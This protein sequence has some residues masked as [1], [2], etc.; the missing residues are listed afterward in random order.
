MEQSV[1]I[2]PDAPDVHFYL[3]EIYFELDDF[4]AAL[5][6]Y[7]QAI[8]LDS[9]F[10]PAYVGRAKARLALDPEVDVSRDFQ[11]AINSDPEYPFV[12]IQRAAFFIFQEDYEAALEDLKAAESLVPESSLIRL[13]RAQIAFSQGDLDSALVFAQDAL[14]REPTSLPSYRILAFV[15][16]ALGN[17][18]A[19]LEPLET[20]TRYIRSDQ[21]AIILLGDTYARLDR[22]QDA[23]WLYERIL[24]EDDTQADV[25]YHRGLA[26]LWSGEAEKALSDFN[27][28][29]RLRRSVF[30]YNIG[31]GR[32]LTALDSP[33]SAY[34]YYNEIAFMAKTNAQLAELYYYRGLSLEALDEVNLELNQWRQLLTLPEDDIP[35]EYWDHA[36][37]R[38]LILDPP[39]PTA[40]RTTTPSATAAPSLTASVEP[41][42]TVTPPATETATVTATPFPSE[43]SSPSPTT[44]P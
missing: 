43:T 6:A 25:F 41:S 36:P 27:A 18:E 37:A 33:G 21:D 39:T 13:Y 38:L 5:A 32:A 3:G 15:Q 34:T 30:E 24:L 1:D 2:S 19:A 10:A 35:T 28:A 7:N 29:N 11:T 20:Y 17:Y 14:D 9:Q 26:Y 31:I 44:E 42:P 4:S 12:Y 16:F 8:L 23:I 22:L 40:T